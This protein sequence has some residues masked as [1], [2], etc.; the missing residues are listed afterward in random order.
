L[1]FY[2]IGKAILM[3]SW[4]SK[5]FFL[6]FLLLPHLLWAQSTAPSIDQ[7]QSQMD[8]LLRPIVQDGW[9]PGVG[10]DL[11]EK[12]QFDLRLVRDGY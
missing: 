11:S 12:T 7:I 10:V 5:T 9:C 3:K 4:F 8:V 6:L 2:E 1:C